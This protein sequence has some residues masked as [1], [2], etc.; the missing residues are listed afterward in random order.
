MKD[1]NVAWL[2]RQ[3][4]FVQQEPK[5]FECSVREN[6]AMGKEGATD[7]EIQAAAKMANAHDFVLGF[8]KG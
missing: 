2:R 5:L 3:M 1:L 8:P 4:A 6:I 7:E